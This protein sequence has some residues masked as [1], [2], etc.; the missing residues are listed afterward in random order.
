[1]DI[2][3]LKKLYDQSNCLVTYKDEDLNILYCNKFMLD[4]VG[5]KCM[6]DIV[7]KTDYDLPWDR[8]ASL[9]TKHERTTFKHPSNTVLWPICD[10]EYTSYVVT[11]QRILVEDCGSKGVLTHTNVLKNLHNLELSNLIEC[12][13]QGF[14]QDDSFEALL[15]MITERESEC[16]FYL[17]R[18][19]TPR[20]IGMLLG[21]SSRTVE[22][23]VEGLRHK[24]G[25]CSRSDLIE[26]A[27]GMGF[28][29]YIPDSLLNYLR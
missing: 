16:L 28:L 5:A 9:Y 26:K 24:F 18:G 7:G 4:F 21:I 19:K 6:E 11:C 10:S 3:I 29:Y 25:S 14:I 1:M 13:D 20:S 23:H 12:G 2:S 15:S 8:Y 27:V 22:G 17:L